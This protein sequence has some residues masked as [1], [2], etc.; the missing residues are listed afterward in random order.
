[1]DK[2][3]RTR[4]NMNSPVAGIDIGESKSDVCYLAPDGDVREQFHFPM[5]D[6]GFVEFASRVPRDTRIVYEASGLAYAVSR[7][8]RD[9]GYSDVTVAHPKELAWITKSKRK[10]DR[11][12]SMKLA[13]LHLVNMIPEAHLLDDDARAIRD[14]LI[15]RVKIGRLIADAKNGITGYLKREDLLR[16]LPDS[17]DNFSAKRMQ[18]MRRLSLGHSGDLVLK[19]QLDRMDLYGKQ[20]SLFDAEIKKK[21]RPNE[22]ARILMSIP[23]VDYYLAS[24]LSSY[25]G[26]VKRFPDSDKLAVY[27]GIVPATRDS[28]SIRRRGHMS[29][30]GP[31]KAR[32]A[33][34]IAVD[35]IM[36]NN[37]AIK[38]YYDAAVKKKQSGKLAHV[39][40]M[41]KLLRMM[42]RMLSE[43]RLWKYDNPALT[44]N[45]FA[46]LEKD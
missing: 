20:A 7:R 37:A 18:A 23:G 10:N 46:R 15:Q 11:V 16:T 44:E 3:K 42:Y 27:F 25:I 9:F 36:M 5:T 2:V 30:D 43:R 31:A 29:R 19:S 39:M 8:L 41:R 33:L 28:S 13:K 17:A 34:S 21:A 1:M 26:D 6:E 14:L 24:L 12:D 4:R 32:W 35:T 45:K 38:N 40:T 22:D